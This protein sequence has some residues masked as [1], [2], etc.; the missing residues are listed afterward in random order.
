[1]QHLSR[2][3]PASSPGADND[4]V[5]SLTRIFTSGLIASILAFTALGVAFAEDKPVQVS[6][7]DQTK[8]STSTTS[9]GVGKAHEGNNGKGR[10]L[11]NGV[12][13]QPEHGRDGE[14]GHKGPGA[15]ELPAFANPVAGSHL[16]AKPAGGSVKVRLPGG[17]QAVEL[18]EVASIPVG[19]IVDAQA[20]AVYLTA[21][22]GQWAG[23]GGGVFRIHQGR[24]K[25]PIT[26]LVLRGGD[27]GSCGPVRAAA[28]KSRSP[29]GRFL[30][31]HGKG[32]FRTRGRHGAAVVRG[33]TW[34]TADTCDGTLVFV[35]SGK[36]AVRDFFRKRTALVG[37]GQ[38]YLAKPGPRRPRS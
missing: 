4:L 33:T 12:D 17:R 27:L 10:A 13:P 26:D 32:R 3:S 21:P 6:D 22:D 1:M 35:K 14:R 38:S 19:S 2:R 20:G 31:G 16:G 18:T 11:G 25:R 36:V 30:W 29:R 28:R 5:P 24:G 8:A 9:T 15:G 34:V 23:F 7:P 37:T